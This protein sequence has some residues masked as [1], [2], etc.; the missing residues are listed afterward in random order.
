LIIEPS[1]TIAFSSTIG[2]SREPI[3]LDRGSNSVWWS[4]TPTRPGPVV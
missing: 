1:A 3:E 4:W 2:A